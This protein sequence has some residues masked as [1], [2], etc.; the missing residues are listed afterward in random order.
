M[1]SFLSKPQQLLRPLLA[2][3]GAHA[4]PRLGRLLPSKSAPDLEALSKRVI[5]PSL[6]VADEDMTRIALWEKGRKL[7]R[8]ERWGDLSRR[9]QLA[10]DARLSTHGGLPET[11][12]LILGAHGDVVAAALDSLS[13]GVAPHPGGVEALEEI[14]LDHSDDYAA[15]LVVAL[16]HLRIGRAW[17]QSD[18]FDEA[19][20]QQAAKKH[21]MRAHDLVAPFD[22]EDLDAPSV[23]MAKCAVAEFAAG[24]PRTDQLTAAYRALISL[25]PDC[26]QHM[27]DY[28]P[29]LLADATG[30]PA[31]L[32]HEADR[33]AALTSDIWREGGYAWVSLDAL[34]TDAT[35]LERLDTARLIAGL[36]DI[37]DLRP[38][39]FTANE[40]AAFCA[41][42]MRPGRQLSASGEKARAALHECLEWILSDHLHELHP[43]IWAETGHKERLATPRQ[44]HRSILAQGRR[45]ALQIIARRFADQLKDGSSIVFSSAGMYRLPAI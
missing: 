16:A 42:T 31:L 11:T 25:D 24:S 22:A 36:R 39:Q 2:D 9:V 19:E 41:V 26:P 32:N 3:K 21:I 6:P 43:R 38:N 37:L 29:L 10:D 18:G 7:A 27:R 12:L 8:Q 34:T 30:D 35:A 33:I 1:P 23:A 28:G 13:D 20:R 4:L 15:T 17:Q 40:C 14:L 5:L 45:T 44:S